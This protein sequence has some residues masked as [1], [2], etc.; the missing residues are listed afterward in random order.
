MCGWIGKN[1]FSSIGKAVHNI[2]PDGIEKKYLHID[3]NQVGCP[4]SKVARFTHPIVAVKNCNGYQR[5][6]V[7]FQSISSTNITPVNFINE[8]ALLVEIRE[9]GK[10]EKIYWGIEMND[11]R[12]M[13]LHI[14]WSIGVAD[15]LLKNAAL[16][17]RTWK[18][19]HASMN[20]R[21]ALV[22]VLAYG[23]YEE[24][25]E[26]L[27]KEDWKVDIKKKKLTLNSERSCL[28]R[29]FR[30]TQRSNSIPK[31]RRCRSSRR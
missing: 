23:M 13:Y 7:S 22:I 12:R 29:C 6:H 10:G 4:R 26:G 1:G 31:M 30:T 11:G 27:I 3:K 14:Y 15:H 16:Y 17:Y 19:W 21:F 28:R 18:Y 5:V 9:R 2:L 25:C 24:C 8:Y 20:H